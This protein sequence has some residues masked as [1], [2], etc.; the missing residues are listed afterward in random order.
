MHVESGPAR[1]DRNYFLA[2]F[3]LCVGMGGYFYYDHVIGYPAKNRAEAGK[4]LALQF[5]KDKVPADL[6]EL[7]EAPTVEDFNALRKSAPTRPEQVRDKLGEPFATVREA[8]QVIEYYVSAYG[9]GRVPINRGQLDVAGMNWITWHKSKD[10]IEFQFYC[11][12][13]AWVI[14]L[15]ILW[16]VYRAATLRAVIDDEG[17]TYGGRRIRFEDMKRLCDY[18]R[19]GWVDLYYQFGNQE[20]RQRIDDQK[21]RKFHEIIDALCAAKGFEDPRAAAEEPEDEEAPAEPSETGADD[22]DKT[23]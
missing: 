11:A 14:G 17:M 13:F 3:V 21:I 16:R 23:T 15:Y 18:S 19:K 4:Q 9:M 8:D 1:Y 5:G 20:R 7:P 22:T 2:F 12:I 6:N 10:E